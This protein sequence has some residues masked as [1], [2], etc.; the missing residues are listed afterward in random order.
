TGELAAPVLRKLLGDLSGVEVLAVENRL[1]GPGVKVAGL[2]GGRDVAR[3]LAGVPADL[4][5]I[6]PASALRDGRFLDE[7]TVEDLAGVRSG[8]VVVAAP[9]GA[10]L[11]AA[12]RGAAGS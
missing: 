10:G 8:P 5:V 7:V 4:R 6:L 3:A 12:V 1:F 2:L 9:T 11:A